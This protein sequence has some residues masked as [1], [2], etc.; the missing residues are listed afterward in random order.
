MSDFDRFYFT[1]EYRDALEYDSTLPPDDINYISPEGM[2]GNEAIGTHP[3]TYPRLTELSSTRF[4]PAPK[5]WAYYLNQSTSLTHNENPIHRYGPLMPNEL[6]GVAYESIALEAIYNVKT[7]RLD[8]SVLG[9][10][11]DLFIPSGQSLGAD[12]I[13]TPVDRPNGG[14]RG[15]YES[16][17]YWEYVFSDDDVNIN[18]GMDFVIQPSIRLVGNSDNPYTFVPKFEFLLYSAGSEISSVSQ[19]LF[20]EGSVDPNITF[21]GQPV[22]SETA[23]TMTSAYELTITAHERWDDADEW[24]SLIQ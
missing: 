8:G 9:F 11:F 20:T 5:S 17:A 4:F 2:V 22:Y 23:S 16:S 6:S 1:R 14:V 19:A 24:V 13:Y 7:W 12:G 18:V 3:N 10:A 21:L 15:A